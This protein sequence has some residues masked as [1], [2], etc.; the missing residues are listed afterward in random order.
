MIYIT[1][2]ASASPLIRNYSEVPLCSF[3]IPSLQFTNLRS[4]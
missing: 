1:L 2:A 4:W 3:K